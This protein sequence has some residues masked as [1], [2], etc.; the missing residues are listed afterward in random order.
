MVYA[1]CVHD[2]SGDWHVTLCPIEGL[3]PSLTGTKYE[4]TVHILSNL[5]PRILS[6]N[7]IIKENVS[8]NTSLSSALTLRLLYN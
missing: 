8:I 3:S 5:L 1:L 7:I 2:Q 4:L 6:L